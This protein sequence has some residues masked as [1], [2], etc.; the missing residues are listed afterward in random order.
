MKEILKSEK[1]SP[2]PQLGTPIADRSEIIQVS[3]KRGNVN[4]LLKKLKAVGGVKIR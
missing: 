1:Q 3:S 2:V 4:T